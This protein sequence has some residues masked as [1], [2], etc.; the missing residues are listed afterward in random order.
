MK[1]YKTIIIALL[2]GFTACNLDEPTHHD[3]QPGDYQNFDFSTVSTYTVSLYFENRQGEPIPGAYT[4]LYT[5]RPLTEEGVFIHD[6]AESLIYKG[7]SNDLGRIES[8]I[9]PASY[10]DSIYVLVK[11]AGI[12]LLT[13]AA[14]ENDF[15]EIW[16]GGDKPLKSSSTTDSIETKSLSVPQQVA[17]YYVLG[18]WD[19]QGYPDYLESEPDI[20][21]NELLEIVDASLPEGS[22]LPLTH[23][24]YLSE[25]AEPN[26]VLV[27][28]A[29]V[30]VTFVHEGAGWK[31]SIGYY[32][33]PN[34]QPPGSINDISDLTLIF[35]NFSLRGS[36][37]NH[38]PGDKVQL[39]YLDPESGM[40]NPVFPAGTSVR[41]FLVANGFRSA[42]N[43]SGTYTHFSNSHLNIES[44]P[45]LQ[46]HNVMLL[47]EER[48]ILMVGFEDIRRDSP[49]CDQDFNDAVFY[50][51]V[52]PYTAIMTESYAPV[53]T[54]ED[55][56]GD[57]I[58]DRFDDYPFDPERAFD[59]FYPGSETFGTLVFEDLW[60]GKGDY[61]FND[62]VVDY[63]FKHVANP[64]NLII[65]ME[66]DIIVRAIGASFANG[67]GIQ[68]DIPQSAVASVTGHR[69]HG[70]YI[71]L[72]S[73]G[74][75]NGQSK[76]TIIAFDNAFRLLTHPGG[77]T[78]VNT[79]PGNVY[80]QPEMIT[81]TIEFSSP[82]ALKDLGVAPYNPFMIVN[83]ERGKEVHLPMH[84]PT[85][86]ADLSLL[87]TLHD[88]SDAAQN[89]YYASN[90]DLPWALNIPES[91]DYP[92]EKADIRNVYLHFDTWARSRG[93]H[94]PDW[95]KNESGYRNQQLI[96]SIPD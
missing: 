31:N 46:R 77:G 15:V 71:S 60:P 57:G 74:T 32:T 17:G 96:F 39:L 19:G 4:E 59:Y 5:Q 49:S 88:D 42:D 92:I 33:Y 54:P 75:E 45:E 81:L 86:L 1:I 58:S 78:G 41:W 25:N 35:P 94:F 80:V 6:A 95:F 51:T 48:E 64:Q 20:I 76:A 12:P 52:S 43:I 14:L 50:T 55:S 18:S 84:P 63:R 21:D 68:L 26:L 22:P 65:E 67:F 29:E 3:E 72:N 70:G 91:F 36:G 23:P 53:D 66:I 28:D 2:A 27:E 83:G 73:N 16:F 61:D 47:D 44:D 82:L 40:F 38:L 13:A 10:H 62:M 85:D 56:D 24:Q 34:N 93:N 37:G 11:R 89:K 8:I 69:L 9:N 87:G 79:T 30:W 90:H 7:V